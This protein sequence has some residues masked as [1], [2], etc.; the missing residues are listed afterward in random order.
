MLIQKRNYIQ[1]QAGVNHHCRRRHHRF[2]S[3]SFK[4]KSKNANEYQAKTEINDCKEHAYRTKIQIQI[5]INTYNAPVTI[6]S[7]TGAV[8]MQ[9]P[10]NK[11]YAMK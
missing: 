9:M 6:K 2:D 5:Q 4:N 10:T 1:Q 7:A 8:Q 3:R 11:N